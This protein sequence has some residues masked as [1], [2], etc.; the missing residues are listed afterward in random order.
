M[1]VAAISGVLSRP[2]EERVLNSGARVVSYEVSV[3]GPDGKA[4]TVPVSWYDPP[5]S[6]SGLDQGTKVVAIGRV[7]QRFFR[8]TSGALASRTEL[9]ASSVLRAGR[10]KAVRDALAKAIG[11]VED[12]EA[13]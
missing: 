2:A 6:G 5:S 12:A 7:R 9:V 3:P 11:E 13:Q 1:N 8:T 4:E 10:T